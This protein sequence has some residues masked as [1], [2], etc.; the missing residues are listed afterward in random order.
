MELNKE[1]YYRYLEEFTMVHDQYTLQE[2]GT[3]SIGSSFLVLRSDNDKIMIS[4]IM[5]GYNVN[6]GAVYKCIYVYPADLTMPAANPSS[7]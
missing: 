5:T 4:F 7:L 2:Y 3:E 1:Y 6:S